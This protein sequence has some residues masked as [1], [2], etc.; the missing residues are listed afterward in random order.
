MRGHKPPPHYEDGK[1]TQL[2]HITFCFLFVFLWI[3]KAS[4]FINFVLEKNSFLNISDPAGYSRLISAVKFGQKLAETGGGGG[5]GACSSPRFLLNSIF[6]E[7][8]KVV[9]KWKIVQN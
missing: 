3:D 7:L 9:L 5:W 6:Y 4:F 2:Q 1:N 8:K